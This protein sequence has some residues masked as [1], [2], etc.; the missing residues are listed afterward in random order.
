MSPS[1]RI[2]ERSDATLREGFTLVEILVVIAIIGILVALLLPAIQAARE[3]ARRMQC[4]NNLR[5]MGVAIHNFASAKKVLPTGGTTF[6][7]HLEDYLSPGGQPYGPDRQGLGWAFQILPYLEEGNAYS[8]KSTADLMKLLIPAYC[9]PSRRQPTLAKD[10]GD[11]SLNNQ[12]SLLFDYVGATPA[13]VVGAT[14]PYSDTD[15]SATSQAATSFWQSAGSSGTIVPA[16]KQW[17]G[18]IVRTPMWWDSTAKVWVDSGSTHPIT[19]EKVPDG[20]SNTLMLGE[21][22]VNPMYYEGGSPSDDRGWSDGWDPDIMRCTCVAPKSDG[23]VVGTK[24]GKGAYQ[25]GEINDVYNFGSAHPSA[26]NA[27]FGDGSVHTISYDIDAVLFDRLGN[28]RD[29]EAVDLSGM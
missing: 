28:R 20:V 16:N 25:F 3:A 10:S 29:G 8:I 6:Y 7:P 9:C 11:T 12:P 15:I 5:Q 17:L 24:V 13:M 14:L 18:M 26:F 4:Q 1:S 22:L 27:V 23:S 2:S 21:K 19:F